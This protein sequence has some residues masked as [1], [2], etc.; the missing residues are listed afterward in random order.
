MILN[1]FAHRR[2]LDFLMQSPQFFSTEAIR[3]AEQTWGK[4]INV[5]TVLDKKWELTAIDPIHWKSLC[6]R[7]LLNGG[8][9]LALKNPHWAI[10]NSGRLGIRYEELVTFFLEVALGKS[11]VHRHVAVQCPE[12]RR[13]LGEFDVIFRDPLF[14]QKVFHWE[15]SVKFYICKQG[16]KDVLS[17]SDC[18]GPSGTDRLDIKGP[19]TFLQQLT[20]SLN[21]LG[22]A[23]I[24]EITTS[25]GVVAQPFSQGFLFRHYKD[26]PLPPRG[27]NPKILSGVWCR[28][29]EWDAL[30]ESLPE[31]NLSILPRLSWLHGCEQQMTWKEAKERSQ[32][33]LKIREEKKE[34][35][36]FSTNAAEA[37]P[38][39]FVTTPAWEENS[40]THNPPFS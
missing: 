2:E 37:P 12:E 7:F 39:I 16:I 38:R 15:L 26:H 33:E 27:I 10:L 13:T 1:S 17:W 14:P 21:P 20:L 5:E 9:E 24:P 3:Y 22:H 18:V 23:A 34:C 25:E 4:R 35:F 19:K 8:L 11:A 40:T 31:C 6:E 32:L 28:W 30:R 36:L 29:S